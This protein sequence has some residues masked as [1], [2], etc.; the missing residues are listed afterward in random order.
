V[1]ALTAALVATQA[2]G[3]RAERDR[4][5]LPSADAPVIVFFGDSITRGQGLNESEAYPAV[6]ERKLAAAGLNFRAVNAGVSGDTTQSALARIDEYTQTRPRVVL[7]ELGANDAWR[8][9]NRLRT[10]QNLFKIVRTFS[11]AGA[12]VVVAG[13]RFAHLQ[14]PALAL[15]LERIYEEVA[16]QTDSD[17]IPDLMTGVAGVR[18]LN[19]EDGLHPNAKGQ[20][21]L[22][23]TALPAVQR[24]IARAR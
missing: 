1:I 17:L 7:V 24:A 18:E 4:T 2:L 6:I 10:R 22:A 12:R 15:A 13:T 5:Q 20:E 14:H 19:L 21:I 11:D 8:G 9:V 23:D 3:C 16:E